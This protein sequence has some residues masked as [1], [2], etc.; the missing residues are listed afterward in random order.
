LNVPHGA[1]AQLALQ[2]TPAA[3]TSFVTSA[4]KLAAVPAVK[5]EST[6]VTNAIEIAGSIVI[7]EAAFFVGSAVD[8]AV[9]VTV[10]P[11]GTLGGAVKFAAD[12][13]AVCEVTEPQAPGLPQV[14]VQSTPR[15][16]GS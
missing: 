13:L 10:A 12:P 5:D 15:L 9:A 11:I 6:G 8:V 1:L 4:V 7:V 3:A 14:N 2:S 16:A